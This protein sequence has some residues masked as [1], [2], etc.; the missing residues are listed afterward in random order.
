VQQAVNNSWTVNVKTYQL[1]D[2][3]D[4]GSLL[5]DETWMATGLQYDTQA[6]QMELSSAIDAIG[7]QA[8]NLRISREAVGA[9]PS[10]GAI[11][12]G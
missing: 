6:V 5:G 4:P 11:R 9:L 1:T 8:P 10:T 7:A 3:Y 12:S 2:T